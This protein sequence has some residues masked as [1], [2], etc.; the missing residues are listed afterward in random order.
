M[1]YIDKLIANVKKMFVKAPLRVQIFKH[2]A[3]SLSLPSQPV[4]TC[5]SMWLEAAMYYCENYSTTEGTVSYFDSNEASSIKIVKILFS[6]NL[7][8][9]LA[10]ISQTLEAYQPQILTWRQLAQ[11]CMTVCF[12]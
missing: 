4:L 8:G 10:Y 3:P 1:L 5:W 12:R 11:K 7:S 9:N 2:D 6:S